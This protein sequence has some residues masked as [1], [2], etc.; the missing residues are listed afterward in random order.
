M[1]GRLVQI[2][3]FL[4][5]ITAQFNQLICKWFACLKK[6]IQFKRTLIWLD[7]IMRMQVSFRILMEKD[8]D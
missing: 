8:Y 3:V 1:L 6:W 2:L 5:D 4:S 7:I